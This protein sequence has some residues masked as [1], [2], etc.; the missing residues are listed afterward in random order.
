MGRGETMR[1]LKFDYLMSLHLPTELRK[2]LQRLIPQ[3]IWRPKRIY[4]VF[5]YLE[6]EIMRAE[7]RNDIYHKKDCETLGNKISQWIKEDEKRMDIYIKEC[8]MRD[9]NEPDNP[10]RFFDRGE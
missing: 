6:A 2:D 7:K 5:G 1:N 9:R 10:D 3:T 8:E 4:T